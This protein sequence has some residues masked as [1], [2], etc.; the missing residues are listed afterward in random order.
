MAKTNST[1]EIGRDKLRDLLTGE[2]VVQGGVAITLACGTDTI[3]G[4]LD[5]V[6]SG[7]EG[8]AEPAAETDAAPATRPTKKR[9][10]RKKSG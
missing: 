3:R 1:L 7:G 8:N 6:E 10:S 9:A 4:L 2:P 5:E